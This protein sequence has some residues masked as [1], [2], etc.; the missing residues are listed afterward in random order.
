MTKPYRAAK[1]SARLTAHKSCA[2]TNDVNLMTA[3]TDCD[4]ALDC[5]NVAPLAAAANFENSANNGAPQ[6]GEEQ[7]G[8]Q[9]HGDANT[10]RGARQSPLFTRKMLWYL[11]LPLVVEQL[12]AVTVGLADT[13]MISSVGDE[14]V[15]EAAVSGISLIDSVNMLLIQVFA[16]LATGGAVV[17]AQYIGRREPDKACKA[18]KQLVFVMAISS[19]LIAALAIGLNG[20]IVK[21]VF[22]NLDA[23]VYENACTYFWLSALSYPFLAIYNAGAAL[24]RAMNNSKVSMF[25]SLAM[26][27]VNVSGNAVTIYALNMGVDGVATA[28][29]VSRAVAAVAMLILITRKRHKIH[30]SGFKPEFDGKM[31]K[32]IFSIGIPNGIENGLFNAGKL[33]VARLVATLGTAAIAAN[34]ISNNIASFANVPGMAIGLGMITVV[35][36]CCGAREFEQAQR[37]ALKLLGAAYL[38]N[39]TINIVLFFSAAPLLGAFGL[40]DSA[41][42]QATNIVRVFSIVCSVLWSPAFALPNALRAS[43]DARFTMTVSVVSMLVMRVGAAYLLVAKTTLGLQAV[44][45]AMYLD[46]AVRTAFF[47][48]RF[49]RGKWKLKHVI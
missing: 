24:F 35:G 14:A 38:A 44:W 39:F 36:Q 25:V 49:A 22:G 33:I 8:V 43:G 37:Y 23:A 29:L 26:N 45:L 16:A 48:F 15:R 47:V 42:V 34:A 21:G 27:V 17:A 32:R 12:L 28:S 2:T 41:T 30:I 5:N 10:P 40:S 7:I 18:A 6:D 9:A 31:I 13:L 46:W 19:T 1:D 4:S 11:I 3:V 20:Y